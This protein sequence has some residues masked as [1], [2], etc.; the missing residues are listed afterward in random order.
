M[1]DDEEI[2]T[3]F[4]TPQH[5][6]KHQLHGIIR[7]LSALVIRVAKNECKCSM[8]QR[9]NGDGCEKCNPRL[10]I[11]LIMEAER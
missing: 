5:L 8:V 4:V 6:T 3:I 2:R 7:E 1:I 10:A 11:D 9:L